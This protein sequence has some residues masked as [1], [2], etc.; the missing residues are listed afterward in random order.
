[1]NNIKRTLSAFLMF[2]VFLVTVSVGS[3]VSAQ[4]GTWATKAPMPSANGHPKGAVVDGIFY[5]MKNISWPFPYPPDQALYAYNPVT[6]QWISRTSMPTPRNSF[7]VGVVDGK[8][9]TVGGWAGWWTE[10]AVE[11]YNPATDSWITGLAPMPKP[12]PYFG[13]GV[14]EGII[15]TIGGY[16][17]NVGYTDTVEA[18]NPA[19]DT[20]TTDLTPMP[21]TRN[22]F[23]VGVIDGT[24]YAVGGSDVSGSPSSKVEAYNPSTNTWTT[25]TSMPTGRNQLTVE[26]IDGILYAIGGV[27]SADDVIDTVEAYDPK[28]N[29][30]TT[31]TPMPTK[32]ANSAS[33]VVEKSLYVAGGRNSDAAPLAVLEAFAPPAPVDYTPP[34]ITIAGIS[35]GMTYILGAVP[36][37]GYTVTDDLSGVASQNETLTGGN[38]NGVGTFV[39]TVTATDNAGNTRTVVITFHVIYSFSGFLSPVSIDKPF[40]FGS[41]IPVKFQLADEKGSLVS[42]AVA[43]IS[44]QKFSGELPFGDPMDAISTSGADTGNRFRYTDNQYIYNLNTNGLS[45]GKWL[46]KVTL[47]DGTEQ[48]K[49]ISFK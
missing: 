16:I 49:F 13:A 22:F 14:V 6:D 35:N 12:R 25:L 18:Y 1:M 37:A 45:T 33:G 34:V 10:A 48:T 32:R 8:I 3:V 39:Y 44:L 43:T 19:T 42:T 17:P 41:T 2:F 28:T 29:N 20:W 27:N 23:G 4:E 24:I 5:V 46:I 47:D 26:A 9:Y 30:W 11:A 38:L 40:K 36:V 7:G 21:T 15:Y 31:M